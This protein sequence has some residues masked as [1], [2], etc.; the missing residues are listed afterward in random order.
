MKEQLEKLIAE[1]G[2]QAVLN[3][4]CV[5]MATK[6]TPLIIGY[7]V[8]WQAAEK[9]SQLAYKLDRVKSGEAR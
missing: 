2:H 6:I 5:I 9:L 8:I 1:H 7:D 3:D 4:L